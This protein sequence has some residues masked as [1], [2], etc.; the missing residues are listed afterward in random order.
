MGDDNKR[1]IVRPQLPISGGKWA[2]VVDKVKA[3]MERAR[4][5]RM[6]SRGYKK[7]KRGG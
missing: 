4:Q 6:K 7:N 5:E 3:D 1:A 2:A